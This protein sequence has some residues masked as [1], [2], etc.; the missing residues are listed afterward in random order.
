MHEKKYKLSVGGIFKNEEHCIVE[1]IEHYLHHGVEHFYLIDDSS[2]DASVEKCK[3]YIEKGIVTLFNQ[4]NQW[5]KYLGRQRDMYNHYILPLI[6][7][8]QWLLMVDLDEFVWSPITHD[9]NDVLSR[10]CMTLGQIQMNNTLYG[11]SG[12]KEQ[13]K[14]IVGHFLMRSSEHPTT[15]NGLGILKYFVN[16][17]FEFCSLNLHHADFSNKDKYE[18]SQYFIIIDPSFFILNHYRIQSRDFWVNIK[19]TRGDADNYRVRD[20]EE[21]YKFDV[22]EEEDRGL[23]EQNKTWL[24]TL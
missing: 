24:D 19:C 21:F 8:T 18:N 1:W 6:K 13:P 2:T 16:S 11:S 7:E 15:K 9:L 12:F 20:M 3:L 4:G 22:N 10:Y 23:Y 17:D 5:S 14:N